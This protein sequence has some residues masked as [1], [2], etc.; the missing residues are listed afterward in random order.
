MKKTIFIILGLAF[1]VMIVWALNTSSASSLLNSKDF[2]SKY[3]S[4]PNA[5]LIDVR[6]PAEFNS[7]HIPDAINIDYENSN[8]K[9]EVKKLD[10][11]KEYFVYCRSGNRSSKAIPIMNSAGINNTYDLSGG[12]VAAPELLK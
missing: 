12:I 1:L 2:I 9:D 4:S 10:P 11:S 5:I 6:T 8:F 3:K 7:G